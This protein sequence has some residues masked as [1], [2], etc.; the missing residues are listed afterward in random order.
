MIPLTIN[1][2]VKEN[3]TLLTNTRIYKSNL[4]HDIHDIIPKKIKR[5]NNNGGAD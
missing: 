3:N 2:Q 4:Y 1:K 5:I